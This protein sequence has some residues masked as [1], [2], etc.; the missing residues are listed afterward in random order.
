MRIAFVSN[1]ARILIC[2]LLLIAMAGC[3]KKVAINPIG[4]WSGHMNS[5]LLVNSDS[6]AMTLD[7]MPNKR[8]LFREMG[9]EG[10]WSLSGTDLD[11]HIDRSGDQPT[12]PVVGKDPMAMSGMSFMDALFQFTISEDGKKLEP[13]GPAFFYFDKI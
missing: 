9:L 8:F 13:R 7:L 4:K 3:K 5:P 10:T 1:L 6:Q 12:V 2:A 11:L